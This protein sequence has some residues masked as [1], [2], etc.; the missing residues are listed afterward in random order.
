MADDDTAI[1]PIEA[2]RARERARNDANAD[3]EAGAGTAPPPF[4]LWSSIDIAEEISKR[5][6][7]TWVG[8]KVG[9]KTL[10]SLPPGESAVI[11]GPTG[12]GKSSLA[13]V[14]AV[15]HARSEGPALF[16]SCEMPP[17]L[18]GS[19]VI[20]QAL[21]RAWS[22]VL[23]GA[24][25][26]SVMGSALPP[27]LYF[28]DHRDALGWQSAATEVAARHPGEPLVVVIDYLQILPM[29]SEARDMRARVAEAVDDISAW[30]I[31]ARATMIV[32]SQTSR[33]AARALRSG[34]AVGWSATDAGAESAS[35]ERAAHVVLAIGER[36]P[37]REDGSYEIAVSI[38]KHRM[39]GGDL[40]APAAYHGATGR[41]SLLGAPR[42]AGDV[43]A[44]RDAA[45]V[46]RRVTS[47]AAAVSD[48]LD[49]ATAPMSR[50][51]V[52][53]ATAMNN[54]AVRAAIARLIESGTI[55]QVE[56]SGKGGRKLWTPA[57]ARAAKLVIVGE[58]IE[59]GDAEGILL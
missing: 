40:V 2:A 24:V 35:I 59:T 51:E 57:R 22:D 18:V 45:R 55:V 26:T 20:G 38:G 44:E 3:P 7:E 4:R 25:E 13:L 19:R 5:A 56:S 10:V 6:A 41:W 52:R 15:A 17:A 46:D 21:D 8:L 29:L 16:V 49:K 34:E 37:D 12:S 53:E 31:E 27:R 39:G 1:T 48:V 50:S 14:M 33:A 11:V 54:S 36:G 32:L 23:R 30:A 9:D 28:V 42:R 47:A 58:T 43:K